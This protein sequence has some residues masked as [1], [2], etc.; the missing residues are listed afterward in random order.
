MFSSLILFLIATARNPVLH[1]SM[2]WLL[3]NL[4]LFD[5]RLL[6]T[7]S[8]LT[9]AGI[10]IFQA[11]SSELNAIS[12]GEEEAIHLGI[13]I[14]RL[15]KIL[16]VITSLVTAAL[17][18]TCGLIGF[19]GL[20]VPHIARSLVGPDHKI[21]IPVSAILGAIFLILSDTLARVIMPPIEIPIGVITSILGGPF[22][23]F[24]LK[25]S[26]KVTQR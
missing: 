23:L 7:V 2:W 21:L 11:Y 16:F 24:L 5:I 26:K 14:E 12:I 17:V 4:Q 19:V 15:K 25:R 6:I 8:V 13:D 9:A 10:L 18:S 3:G 22:F 1:D 20:I